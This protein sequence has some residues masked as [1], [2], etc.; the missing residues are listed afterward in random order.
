MGGDW[1]DSIVI[2]RAEG[3]IGEITV[4]EERLLVDE[5]KRLR[6]QREA[7]QRE[8]ARLSNRFTSIHASL[9]KELSWAALGPD[10]ID[11]LL[12]A[13]IRQRR[14]AM[15]ELSEIHDVLAEALGY[16]KAPTLEE[17]PNC[18]CP[19]GYITG[20]HTAG[21][22]AMEAAKKLVNTEKRLGINREARVSYEQAIT[23]SVD[24]IVELQRELAARKWQC[25]C[26][27]WAHMDKIMPNPDCPAHGVETFDDHVTKSGK[28]AEL[29]REIEALR[30]VCSCPYSTDTNYL[31]WD[32]AC[33]AHG[34]E[35][36]N[37]RDA[38]EKAL[39][40]LAYV[41]KYF[42]GSEHGHEV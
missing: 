3:Y 26:T 37:K 19:G 10:D 14:G 20:D 28:K 8:A 41:R 1:F 33:P 25:N 30:H 18:P 9:V 32:A 31:A 13:I 27:Y 5:I 7:I 39:N 40:T 12:T 6:E 24:Q 2:R 34:D 15:T 35:A 38:G 23:N 17:D 4:T 22:L 16:Q 11:V 21:T 42:M 36:R 29:R